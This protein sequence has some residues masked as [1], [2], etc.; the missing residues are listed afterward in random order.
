MALTRVSVVGVGK[1]LRE[2]AILVTFWWGQRRRFIVLNRKWERLILVQF[3]P[4]PSLVLLLPVAS[5]VIL[6][7]PA[8]ALRIVEQVETLIER[9]TSSLPTFGI[10]RFSEH[11][12]ET[13]RFRT[14]VIDDQESLLRRVHSSSPVLVL[15]SYKSTTQKY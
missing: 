8:G 1:L 10:A 14:I 15:P 7:D 6:M 11:A 5:V 13:P 12:P 9:D 4:L 3:L 2:E